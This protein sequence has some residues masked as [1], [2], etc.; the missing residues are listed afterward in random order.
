[1]LYRLCAYDPELTLQLILYCGELD[2]IQ[3]IG[4]MAFKHHKTAQV[5]FLLLLIKGWI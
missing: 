1:M 5:I 3:W 2:C 4:H